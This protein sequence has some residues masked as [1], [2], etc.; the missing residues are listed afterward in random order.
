MKYLISYSETLKV[1]SLSN[2]SKKYKPTL[3]E[4][5]S[6]LDKELSTIGFSIRRCGD[7]EYSTVALDT[8]EIG[9]IIDFDKSTYIDFYAEEFS[10][11]ALRKECNK[12]LDD[13]KS[14]W[15]CSDEVKDNYDLLCMTILTFLD[16][17]KYTE[18]KKKK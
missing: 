1:P 13:D 8:I 17:R 12:D 6:E 11:E 3:N 2:E 9:E 15:P 18:I 14:T 4:F 10:I 5:I 16:D 7:G